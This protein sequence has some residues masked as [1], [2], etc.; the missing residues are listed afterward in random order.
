MAAASPSVG[1]WKPPYT[2]AGSSRGQSRTHS[3]GSTSA[4]GTPQDVARP[5]LRLRSSHRCGVVATSRPP[6]DRKHPRAWYL[7]TVYRANSVIVFDALVWNTR[8]G[9]CEEEPPVANSGPW[10]TTVTPVH[11]R[12]VS[13]S[14][15]AQPTTP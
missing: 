10:S 2:R 8:P 13:S 3:A 9:A 15:T 1:V 4:F 12:L 6:T 7:A 14:A 11:P 5:C